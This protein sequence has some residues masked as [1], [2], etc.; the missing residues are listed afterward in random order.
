MANT[1][2]RSRIKRIFSSGTLV[3]VLG[4]NK[5]RVMDT[6]ERQMYPKSRHGNKIGYG[7]IHRGAATGQR[8]NNIAYLTNRRDLFR[9]YECIAGNT[10]IPLPDG[11][12]KTIQE[13]AELYPTAND[14][15]YVYSYDH[16]NDN[17][18]IGT[19]HSVRKTKTDQTYKILFDDG[20]HLIAT[21]NH[22]FLMRNGEYKKVKDL[23]PGESVM[24]FYQKHF[25]DQRYRFVYGFSDKWISEHRLVATQFN[26]PLFS[27][28]IV[29]HKDFNK[30][31]NLP[32]NLEIMDDSEHRAYHARINNTK[33]WSPENYDKQCAAISNGLLNANLSWNGKRVGKNNPFFGKSHTTES[34]KKRSKSLK[35]YHTHIDN[36]LKWIG[37]NNGRYRP[38][39][40]Y[41]IIEE[42]SYD[43]YRNNSKLTKYQLLSKIDC[44]GRLLMNRISKSGYNDWQAFKT[45]IE[46]SLNHKI[47]SIELHEVLDVY[48]MTVEKYHNFATDVCFVHNSMDNDAIISSALDI[49]ADECTKKNELGNIINISSSDDEIQQILHN[50]FYDILNIEFNIWPWVR[51]VCKYGDFFLGLQIKEN[52]GIQNVV[53]LS[54]YEIIREEG[55]DPENPSDIRFQYDGVYGKKEFHNFEIAHFRLLNDSNF[56][57]YGKSVV[58]NARRVW[59]QATLLED[60]MLIHRIM[61][62]PERRVFKLDVGNINPADVDAYIKKQQATLKKIPYINPATGD[63]NLKYNIQNLTED[64]FLPVRGGDSGTSIENLPGLEYQAIDDLEFIQKRM[65]AALKIPRAYLGYEEDTSGKAVLAAEDFR[66]AGTVERI[67]RMIASELYKIAA[68]HLYAL[69]KTDESLVN[70]TLSLTINSTVYE[71]EKIRIWQEKIRTAADAKENKMISEDWL[72]DNIFGFSEAEIKDQRERVVEDTMRTFRLQQI[73]EEGNDPVDSGQN[74]KDGEVV[75]PFAP[76]PALDGDDDDDGDTKSPADYSGDEFKK[77]GRPRENQTKYGTD[78]HSNGRDPLGNKENHQAFSKNEILLKIQNM[79]SK[80]GMLIEKAASNGSSM[81]DETNIIE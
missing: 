24:P 73:L 10:I 56:I 12:N 6:D 59:K 57:P 63:Y 40:T 34:N 60:A 65:F 23:I 3:R 25:F 29:H 17:I 69:G 54:A 13:L 37:N 2:F 14:T 46:S 45:H 4:T 11:N 66:F 67:Q 36:K 20:S 75:D 22:P 68:V 5:I 30:E 35:E 77:G 43:L 44:S 58:E 80:K 47:V 78:K 81:M 49:Y 41:D 42:I 38:D 64:F 1:D 28:E 70:F 62:A 18:Q 26:R 71:Q 52:E 51:S 50:L 53:P 16:S 19:A 48:D 55:F 74:V 9:D 15:F 72:Y 61:R 31:N 79:K 32:S 21:D 33:L 8:E 7:S 76:K 39:I 27:N